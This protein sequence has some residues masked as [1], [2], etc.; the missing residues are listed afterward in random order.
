LTIFAAPGATVE[1]ALQWPV[2]GLVGTLGVRII[3]TPSGSTFL[4]RTTAGIVEN[5]VGSGLY[6]WSGTGPTTAGTYSVIWDDGATTPGHTALEELVCTSTAISSA[7][8][9]GIDLCT[10]ADV[11]LAMEQGVASTSLDPLIQT[12]ITAAS[13]MIPNRYQRDFAPVTSATYTFKVIGFMVDLSPHDLRTVT[14][15]T[16]DPQGTATVL[17]ATQYRLSPSGGE[18]NLGTYTAVEVSR[19]QNLYS[20]SITNF[21]YTEL[22]IA[23]AWGPAAV[24]DDVRRA[25]ALTVASWM[26]ARISDSSSSLLGD[27]AQESRDVRPDRFG[28]FAIPF[29]AHMILEQ[30]DRPAASFA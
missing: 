28:G 5:P 4:A 27:L 30:Y 18:S 1:A 13:N 21:G 16:L 15:V 23:G 6:E 17:A 19:L 24:T 3:D 2:T 25:C 9:S 22:G 12:L 10:V 8:P 11:K 20:S 26:S 7:S 14:T 29:D